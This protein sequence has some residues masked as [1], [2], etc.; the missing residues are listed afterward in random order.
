MTTETTE[1]SHTHTDDADVDTS[2][3]LGTETDV[4]S[5]DVETTTEATDFTV[6]EEFLGNKR[7]EGID[8]QDKLFSAIAEMGA[9][10]EYTFEGVPEDVAAKITEQAKALDMSQ[11]QVD[12]MLE[13]EK[14]D[15]K[16]EHDAMWAEVNKGVSGLK[17]EWG[18]D[19][20][21]KVAEANKA[22]K[23]FDEGGEVSKLLRDN[24]KL[25]SSPAFIKFFNKIHAQIDTD[26]FI[27]SDG[28]PKHVP[29]DEHGNTYFSDYDASM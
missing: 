28:S 27:D 8:S 12:K 19:F 29:K 1:P 22:I 26:K 18:E 11:S 10:E 16:S 17:D 21:S 4:E 15:E 6:P 24:P 25:G 13:F 23:A 20:D 5:T 7:F 9:P 3:L 2:G 14:A